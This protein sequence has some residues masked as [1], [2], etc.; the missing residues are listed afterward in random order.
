MMESQDLHE[1]SNSPNTQETIFDV[2]H[3]IE[4]LLA[5]LPDASQSTHS[6][7]L[8][9]LRRRRNALVPLYQLPVELLLTIVRFYLQWTVV[10]GR[11]YSHFMKLS[12]V[13]L[14]IPGVEMCLVRSRNQPLDI[15]LDSIK[16]AVEKEGPSINQ[17]KWEDVFKIERDYEKAFLD[18]V[19]PHFSRVRVASFRIEAESWILLRT[20]LGS[21]APL[22]QTFRIEGRGRRDSFPLPPVNGVDAFSG[23]APRLKTLSIGKEFHF[24]VGCYKFSGLSSLSIW[25]DK[26]L[27]VDEIITILSGSPNLSSL[28]IIEWMTAR[29]FDPSLGA[30]ASNEAL[31]E[32]IIFPILL[33]KLRR[34]TLR[35]EGAD[36]ILYLLEHIQSPSCHHLDLRHGRAT[37][38]PHFVRGSL[39]PFLPAFRQARR[40]PDMSIH[41]GPLSGFQCEEDGPS[42]FIQTTSDTLE[43]PIQ[44]TALLDWIIEGRANHPSNLEN[45]LLLR[46]Q[47]VRLDCSQPEILTRLQRLGLIGALIL[48]GSTSNQEWIRKLMETNG[49]NSDENPQFFLPEVVMLYLSG[50]TRPGKLLAEVL[51]VRYGK[52]PLPT[53]DQPQQLPRP[54]KYLKIAG[55]SPSGYLSTIKSIVGENHVKTSKYHFPPFETTSSNVRA[56]ANPNFSFANGAKDIRP[57]QRELSLAKLTIIPIKS[58]IK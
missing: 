12:L 34:L 43:S 19:L 46:E 31:P 27:V 45:G 35:L 33:P 15:H 37:A 22:L 14:P 58:I 18:R 25:S 5:T 9:E 55:P 11:H 3:R 1:I 42:V 20:V 40:W 23:H 21:A 47:G 39:H 24:L 17:G 53:G 30:K 38:P 4:T 49:P 51:Q 8:I 36:R 26:T 13:R 56:G 48:D 7:Q 16:Y 28:I 54:L 41:L 52:S 50:F 10:Y 6:P 2:E 57:S 44:V 32:Q 29:D